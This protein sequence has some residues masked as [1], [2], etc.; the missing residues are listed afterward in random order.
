METLYLLNVCVKIESV[1]DGCTCRSSVG[2]KYPSLSLHSKDV[3]PLLLWG[4]CPW[5]M[6]HVTCH[7][8]PVTCFM[9]NVSCLMSHV[10]YLMSHVTYLT[11]LFFIAASSSSKSLIVGWSVC[12]SVC[13]SV[14]RLC[15]KVTFRISDSN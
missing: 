6:S 1:V 9:S 2:Q 11:M 3:I 7:M 13:L 12:R 8:S 14:W 4:G 15:E 10:T 5:D